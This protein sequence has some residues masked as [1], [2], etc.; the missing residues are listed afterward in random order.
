MPRRRKPHDEHWHWET[1]LKDLC[2]KR[3]DFREGRLTVQQFTKA[4]SDLA[5]DIIAYRPRR[6]AKDVS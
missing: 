1:R 5:D 6:R 3:I 2:Q 4:V